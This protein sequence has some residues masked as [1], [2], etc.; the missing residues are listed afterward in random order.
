MR[1]FLFF[2]AFVLFISI[3]LRAQF[4][5]SVSN[6]LRY[7][8][9]E[10]SLGTVNQSLKYFENLTDV[11]IQ[12]PENFTAGFRLLYDIPPEVGLEFKGIRRRFFEYDGADFS[13]RIGD[14]SQLYGRGLAMNLFESRGLGY[15]TWMDG[16]KAKYKNDYFNISALFGT[17]DFRDSIIFARNEIHK[18]RGGNIELTPVKNLSVGLTYIY[19]RSSLKLFGENK[20]LEINIPSVYAN[21]S[22]SDFT[23]SFDYANKETKNKSDKK[24]SNGAAYYSAVSFNADGLG[25]TLDYKNYFFDERDPFEKNDITRSSRMMPFQN[26][27]IVLKEHSY[28]LLTRAIHEVDFNDETG[29]QLEI[30]KSLNEYTDLNINGSISSRHSF[31]KF[32]PNH[33]IFNKHERS[34]DFLPSFS[35]EYSPYWELFGEAVHYFDEST[36]M[37]LALARRDKI[38]YDEF[39]GGRSNHV[40]KSAIFAL[41]IS[42]SV[43]SLYSFEGQVEYES[44]YDNFNG[45]QKNY[46]N[47]L[48][49]LINTIESQYTFTVRYEWTNNRFDVSDRIDWITFESGLRITQAN[50]V[51]ASYGRE[52]GG[53]VCSNGVCRYIQPFEG[54]R[55]SLL[56][57]I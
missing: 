46:N 14:F 7:G 5:A 33:F 42:H 28:T 30:F 10:R 20:E 21:Y 57:N 25:I 34:D 22:F 39:F 1:Y 2:S 49:T 24:I 16:I 37:K 29:L 47:Y 3:E 31:Y 9:G 6:T 43:S 44:V 50:T 32:D 26:P 23:F 53:Q 48:I 56:T 11:R 15:D 27:P 18:L 40:I 38:F 17:L 41:Q 8:N 36:Y 19:S 54:F 12:L 13:A 4:D 35:E 45:E 52:R 51:V 55:F